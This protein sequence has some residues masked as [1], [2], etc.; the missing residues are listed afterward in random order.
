MLRQNLWIGA[1]VLGLI[2]GCEKKEK[3]NV[4]VSP[5]RPAE[6]SVDTRNNERVDTR[7]NPMRNDD[8]TV[9]NTD[10]PSV[11]QGGGSTRAAVQS[12]VAARCTRE[13]RCNNIGADHKYA[14]LAECSAKLSEDRKDDLNAKDCPRG[15][16]QK[17]LGECLAEIKNEDCNNPLDSLGRLAACRSSDLCMST[18]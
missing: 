14:S 4:D 10:E 17:E 7:D 13:A 16:S 6:P 9:R 11:Q 1:A 2:C 5:S 18:P 15:V 3:P 8:D 12:I